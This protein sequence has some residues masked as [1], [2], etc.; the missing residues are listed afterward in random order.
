MLRVEGIF[1]MDLVATLLEVLLEL[2]ELVFDT[3]VETEDVVFDELL[4]LLL[5]A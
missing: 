5:G 3:D 1:A 4:S 2:F